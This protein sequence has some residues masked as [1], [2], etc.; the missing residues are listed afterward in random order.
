MDL[1]AKS[2]TAGKRRMLDLVP[3]LDDPKN[4]YGELVAARKV[5]EVA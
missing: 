5:A 1:E 3:E 4:L 2:L